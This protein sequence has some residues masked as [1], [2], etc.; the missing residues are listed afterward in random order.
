MK[1]LEEMIGNL[2]KAKMVARSSGRNCYVSNPHIVFEERRVNDTLV[3]KN[4]CTIDYRN[5]NNIIKSESYPL[6]IIDEV[7]HTVA[8]NGKIFS[9]ADVT[10]YFFQ[11]PMEENSRKYTCFYYKD[12]I[13]EWL[14]GGMGLKTLPPHAQRTSDYMMKS[15]E[16]CAKGFIDDFIV[17][18]MN[19]KNAIKDFRKFLIVCS[20][21]NL[22]LQPKKSNILRKI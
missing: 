20:Y 5:L 16:Y 7:L 12:Q 11:I 3:R 13:L 9:V 22:K 2:M 21:F 14:R 1:V 8:N 19:Y 15:I 6:K 18:S 17:Y 4:R 10:S